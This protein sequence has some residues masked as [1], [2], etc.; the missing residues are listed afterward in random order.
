MRNEDEEDDERDPLE[1]CVF[2]EDD[3]KRQIPIHL[4]MAD[5]LP[6]YAP[7]EFVALQI[8]AFTEDVHFYPDMETYDN[9]T[10]FDLP[11]GR[12]SFG[13]GTILNTGVDDF[14]TV[15]GVITSVD[16]LKSYDLDKEM[17]FQRVVVKTTL[18]D[19]PLYFRPD[20]VDESELTY[21]R[22]GAYLNATCVLSADVCVED[23]QGGAVYDR[24]HC[25]KVFGD[26]SDNLVRVDRM[27]AVFSKDAIYKSVLGKCSLQGNEA[28]TEWFREGPQR[29][30][31]QTWSTLVRVTGKMEEG[32]LHRYEY[33]ETALLR[34]YAI[35]ARFKQIVLVDMDSDGKI[36]NMLLTDPSK[37]IVESMNPSY[38]NLVRNEETCL[39]V[40][41]E[42]MDSGDCTPL[43]ELF[44]WD[45]VLNDG[46]DLQSGI[47]EVIGFFASYL[48]LS[49][50]KEVPLNVYIVR[51]GE[52][53]NGRTSAKGRIGLALS[54]SDLAHYEML[55]ILHMV[56]GR[57]GR[58]D[59][60]RDSD[61]ILEE[62]PLDHDICRHDCTTLRENPEQRTEEDW[63]EHL[64][65]L[66][67]GNDEGYFTFFFGTTPD[68]VLEDE[69]SGEVLNGRLEVTERI[70][71][72]VQLN[73]SRSAEIILQM[74]GRMSVRAGG[75]KYLIETTEAG[76]MSM[77]RIPKA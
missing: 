68:C 26:A 36:K 42:C 67:E 4:V 7:G 6:S 62:L 48:L 11:F 8:A 47:Y 14:C 32:V 43:L 56:E 54:V 18:G 75:R 63:V 3:E 30:V 69:V 55:L 33:P 5:A 59:V 77:I 22:E 57:I 28:I 72:L 34:A 45:V 23:Y 40:I 39:N 73:T 20:I 12:V 60:L 52:H 27:S 9:M 19:L 25:L 49:K 16:M 24:E 41:K 29:N 70:K 31:R 64:S 17:Y 10:G 53:K 1:I 44:T 58:I 50:E 13:N 74:D 71:E 46:D 38:P 35:P 51:V 2:F 37:Y 66:L 15:N 61:Y 76:L 21:M 65:S